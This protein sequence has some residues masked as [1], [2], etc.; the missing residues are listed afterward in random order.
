MKDAATPSA[1][2]VANGRRCPKCSY[3]LPAG[4]RGWP[5]DF[6]R[7]MA[8]HSPRASRRWFCCGVPA[9]QA[10]KHGLDA[11]SRKWRGKLNMVTVGGCGKSFSRRDSYKRHLG[12]ESG[13]VGGVE[14]RGGFHECHDLSVRTSTYLAN[15]KVAGVP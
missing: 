12:R 14:D 8:T 3:T 2:P 9:N 5:S 13:K 1:A 15:G 7:H 11:T 4:H 10:N 6:K